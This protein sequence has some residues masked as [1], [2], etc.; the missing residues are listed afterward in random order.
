MKKKAI[1]LL[2]LCLLVLASCSK[3][4]EAKTYKRYEASFLTLFDT[5]TT[6]L[7]YAENEEEFRQLSQNIHD[8]LLLYH[9]LF[10]IY[11][12]YE[13]INNIKTIND[14]AGVKPVVVDK[15]I[16]DFLL[17]CNDMQ[18]ESDKVNIAMGSVLSIWHDKRTEALDNPLTA[19][20]PDEE[21][22][23][24]AALHTDFSKIHIDEENSTVFIE[25]SSMSLDV[26]AIA[27]G[28]ATE[29]V[30]DS[31]PGIYLLS[32]GGNVSSSNVKPDGTP[33]VVG[34]QDADG[35]IGKNKHTVYLEK[36]SVVTSGVY[37]RYYTVDGIE[38]HHIIDPETLYPGLKWK[39]VSVI[40]PD[41]AVADF[42]STALFLSDVE[43][44]QKLLD[45]YNAVA[46]WTTLDGKEIM[47]DGFQDIM[48]T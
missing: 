38:Y 24:E 15:K 29:R 16:I 1:A 10:D 45:K 40:A 7:G 3:G 41:S 43:A 32:V 4:E 39:A 27:K 9:Q 6:V 14:N 36:G 5:V 2:L 31:V 34:L 23:K 21:V 18:K 25:D 11:N 35:E 17:F 19:V 37:Q 42:L 20:L 8:E 33:W 22:L 48:R 46:I 28:Y 47:S 12:S 30:V 13:G 26:G 44:G